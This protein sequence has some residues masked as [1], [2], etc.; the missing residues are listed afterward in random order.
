MN[1]STGFTLLELVIAIGIIAV[2]SVVAVVN[3]SSIQQNTRDVKRMSDL[4]LIQGSLEQYYAD[5]HV[6]PQNFG[7]NLTSA[8]GTRVY[9]NK[10][11]TEPQ[12]SN[13]PYLYAAKPDGCTA[14]TCTNYCL[15]AAL[16][17]A[18]NSIKGSPYNTTCPLRTNYNFL[19]TQP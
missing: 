2:L 4:R 19:L 12:S 9:L 14:T 15:Y 7:T 16:E 6:Y 3:L 11:P 5:Q 1:K 18:N 8:G 17:N 13:Q 10:V